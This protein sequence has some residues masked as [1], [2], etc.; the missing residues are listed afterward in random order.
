MFSC[1]FK[2]GSILFI[3]LCVRD[4]G[5]YLLGTVI[6]SWLIVLLTRVPFISSDE[7][8]LKSILSDSEVTAPACLRPGGLFS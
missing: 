1:D 8:D 7:F 2:S 4:V 6:S 5:E 3:K